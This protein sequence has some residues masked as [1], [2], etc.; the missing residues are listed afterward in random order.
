MIL[1]YSRHGEALRDTPLSY[2]ARPSTGNRNARFHAGF[3]AVPLSI[4]A[5]ESDMPNP[6]HARLCTLQLVG[7]FALVS[8]LGVRVVGQREGL[9]T[10]TR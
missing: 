6:L 3:H 10:A 8:G 5:P 4:S 1:E 7:M 9:T 2:I